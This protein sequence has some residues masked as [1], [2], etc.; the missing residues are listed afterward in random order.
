M[1]KQKALKSLYPSL[2]NSINASPACAATAVIQCSIF[3]TQNWSSAIV[4]ENSAN[5]IVTYNRIDF[6]GTIRLMPV[7]LTVV[8]LCSGILPLFSH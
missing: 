8:F 7:A 4:M 5:K 3:H 2:I 6:F 1:N